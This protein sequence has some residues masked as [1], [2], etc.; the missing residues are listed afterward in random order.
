MMNEIKE[1]INKILEEQQVKNTWLL[2]QLAA[3]NK[4]LTEAKVLLEQK[5]NS[6]VNLT[7][8]LKS[9]K[10][11]EASEKDK[12]RSINQIK[13]TSTKEEELKTEMQPNK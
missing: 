12:E 8:Q 6:V 1:G 7:Q 13:V 2:E 10:I 11:S 4:E 9:V 5:S 3:K